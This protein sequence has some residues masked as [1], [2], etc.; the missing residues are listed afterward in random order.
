MKLDH[1][2][3][4]VHEDYFETVVE[5][6]TN[7]LGCVE[8]IRHPGAVWLSQGDCPI[9]IQLSRSTTAER[10]ADK[11]K[12]QIAFRA[13]EPKQALERLSRWLE[14]R[15]VRSSVGSY[16]PTDH[17]LDAPDAFIDFVI[18]AIPPKRA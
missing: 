2:A 9:R 12:S 1:F 14:E 5:L 8:G 18:E 6:F 11:P 4:R 16:N 7:Q 10:D 13:P 3:N 15:G 17:F